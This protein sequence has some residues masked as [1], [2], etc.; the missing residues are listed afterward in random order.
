VN[1]ENASYYLVQSAFLDVQTF[2]D[3]TQ[4]AA[5][6]TPGF[7]PPAG[8]MPYP[9]ASLV[10]IRENLKVI[11][12]VEKFKQLA[13]LNWPPSPGYYPDILTFAHQYPG[14]LQTQEFA[15]LVASKFDGSLWSER[16]KFWSETRFFPGR[17]KFVQ[18]AIEEF[19]EGDWVSATYVI[20]PQFE[21]I[22]GDYLTSAGVTPH[23]RFRY[24]LDQLMR[25][26][27]SRRLLLFPRSVIEVIFDFLRTGTFW[28]DTSTI[29][30]PA[31]EVNRHGIA[32]GVFTEFATRDIALKHLLLLDSLALVLLQDKTLTGRLQ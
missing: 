3:F 11:K 24:Q 4:G 25:L 19:L 7:G 2:M 29:G 14:K 22:I 26:I 8:P 23:S 18:K 12:P 20:V 1:G 31:Q 6:Q 5:Q 13:A 21:G 10:Q 17:L 27:F 15:D 30:D 32:H 16:L 9:I 28:N